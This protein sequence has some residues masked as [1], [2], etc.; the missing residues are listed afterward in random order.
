MRAHLLLLVVV[1]HREGRHYV[2][3]VRGSELSTDDGFD[4]GGLG[5]DTDL[6]LC[7]YLFSAMSGT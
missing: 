4:T 7:R 3:P 5:C 1:G 2:R 6:L